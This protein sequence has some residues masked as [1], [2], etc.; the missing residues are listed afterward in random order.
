MALRRPS[1]KPSE[2]PEAPAAEHRPIADQFKRK[3]LSHDVASHIASLLATKDLLPGQ[4][5]YERELAESLGISRVPVREAMRV[6]HAQ[7]IVQIEPNRG[8]RL[9]NFGPEE[10]EDMV[11]LRVGIERAAL[12][13]VLKR[14]NVIPQLVA[15]LQTSVEDMRRAAVLNDY[16]AHCRADLEFHRKI[17]KAAESPLL[18]PIWDT[19]S[20]VI[21]IFLM[22]QQGE[23]NGNP[24]IGK[25]KH[26]QLISLI[27]SGKGEALHNLIESHITSKKP[28][29]RV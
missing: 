21:L 13:R 27:Q 23:W 18:Q 19:L 6:L 5:V 12:R 2:K 11:E 1:P 10:M 9:A 4:R 8:A 17:I 25:T 14:P 29:R 20:N 28:K 22:E 15:D 3:S 26:L 7:G 16:L 24:M